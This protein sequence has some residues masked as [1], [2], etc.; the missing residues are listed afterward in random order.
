[1][2]SSSVPVAPACGLPLVLPRQVSTP[3]VYRSYFL[4]EVTQSLHKVES[5]LL[6]ETCMKM[7]GGGTC[8]TP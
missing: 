5:T 7:T 1:M 6:L 4:R 3:R 2:P 8:T